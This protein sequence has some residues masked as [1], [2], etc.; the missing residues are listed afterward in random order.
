M[1]EMTA[2]CDDLG[3]WIVRLPDID[4]RLDM[5]VAGPLAAAEFGGALAYLVVCPADGP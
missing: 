2:T 1:P 4:Q 3:Y 5:A